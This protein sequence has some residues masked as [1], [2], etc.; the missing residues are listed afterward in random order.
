M[1]FIEKPRLVREVMMGID[2]KE[3]IEASVFESEVFRA[4]T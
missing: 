4:A 2:A 3:V 1:G